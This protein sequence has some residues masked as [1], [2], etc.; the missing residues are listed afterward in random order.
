M[1]LDYKILE[2]IVKN[3]ITATA[4]GIITYVACRVCDLIY[5]EFL[6]ESES[7]Y[8]DEINKSFIKSRVYNFY[9]DPSGLFAAVKLEL[10]QFPTFRTLYR[11]ARGE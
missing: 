2:E 5:M 6:D 8:L 10:T 3:P 7:V 9:Q 1:D 11:K 4:F